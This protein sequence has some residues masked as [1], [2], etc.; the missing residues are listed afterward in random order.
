MSS[1]SKSTTK[2]QEHLSIVKFATLG[3]GVQEIAFD[4]VMMPLMEALK[5]AELTADDCQVRLKRNGETVVVAKPEGLSVQD[6]DVVFL[7]PPVYGG[8]S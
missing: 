4:A 1:K 8:N 7:I 5:R 2:K 6:G 3:N